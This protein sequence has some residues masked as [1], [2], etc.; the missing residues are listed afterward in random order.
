M[1]QCDMCGQTLK[2]VQKR[3]CGNACF[4]KWRLTPERA[5][6][7]STFLREAHRRNPA[8]REKLSHR[9]WLNPPMAN[10]KSRLK[11]KATLLAMKHRPKV[12]GGNGTGPTPA[13]QLLL[14][15]FPEASSNYS[16]R[17]HMPSGSGYPGAYKMDLAWPKLQLAVEADGPSHGTRERQAQDLKKSA[18]LA[19]LGWIVLRFSNKR[20]TQSLE[21]VVAELKS[22]ISR[23]EA[24]RATA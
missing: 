8:W 13:E 12:R 10:D 23:L 3:F 17:T 15:H 14:T 16:V 6:L 2:R 21:V 22:L 9:M 18:L 5:E 7:Y 1:K 24:T 20:I 19:E 4:Q 11:M